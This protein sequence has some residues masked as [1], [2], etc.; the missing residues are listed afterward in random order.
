MLFGLLSLLLICPMMGASFVL[1]VMILELLDGFAF[2]CIVVLIVFSIALIIGAACFTW[3]Q[4]LAFS[5][6][7]SYKKGRYQ[8]KNGLLRMSINNMEQDTPLIVNICH[9]RGDYG[10]RI[11]L[12]SKLGI[13]LMI[14]PSVIVGSEN[15]TLKKVKDLIEW[16]ESNGIKA[17]KI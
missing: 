12:P 10:Y 14:Q 16:L 15:D 2:V 1:Y 7:S 4:G 8:L 13:P 3:L 6:N 9:M 5:F 11:H 17:T